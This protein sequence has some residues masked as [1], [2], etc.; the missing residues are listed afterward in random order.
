MIVPKSSAQHG[1][2]AISFVDRH[3]LKGKFFFFLISD[4]VFEAH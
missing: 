2:F 4:F 1:L 3:A